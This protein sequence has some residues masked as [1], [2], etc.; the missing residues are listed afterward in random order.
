[1]GVDLDRLVATKF[2]LSCLTEC[3]DEFDRVQVKMQYQLPIQF[4]ITMEYKYNV[5]I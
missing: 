5:S 1:M 3:R 2:P 4:S